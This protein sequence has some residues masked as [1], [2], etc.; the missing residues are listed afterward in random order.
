MIE[1]L[2]LG[3]ISSHK[4]W[5]VNCALVGTNIFVFFKRKK[6][7]VNLLGKMSKSEG[8]TLERE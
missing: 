5:N 7:V 4:C 1:N 3:N 6:G 8:E 2:G